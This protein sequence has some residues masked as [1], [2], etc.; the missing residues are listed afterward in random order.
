MAT[1]TPIRFSGLVSGIDFDQV[2]NAILDLRRQP[3]LRLQEER[4]KLRLRSELWQEIQKALSSLQSALSPLL[5]K[6]KGLPFKVTVSDPTV[7]QASANN[8]ALSG[9]YK[10]TVLQLATAVR[11]ATR[12]ADGATSLSADPNNKVNPNASLASESNKF[13]VV[14]STSGS[15]R[16]NGVEIPYRETDTLATILQRINNSAAG[17][18]AFYDPIADRVVLV[19]KQTGANGTIQ[20]EDVSGNFLAALGL[21]DDAQVTPGQD[22]L[23]MVEANGYFFNDGNPIARPSNT[24]TDVLPGIT[25][26]LLSAASDRPVTLIVEQDKSALKSAIKTFVEKFNAAVSLLHQRLTE[27]PVDNP[28]TDAE[29]KVGLLR[30]DSTVVN[31]KATLV[32]EATSVVE[33]IGSDLQ[34]LAQLGIRLNNDGTLSLDENRLQQVLDTMPERVLQVF[35]NDTDGD[36]RVDETDGGIAVRLKILLDGWLS[37]LPVAFGGISLPRGVVARQP[38]LINQQVQQLDR[39]INELNQ[40]IEREGER[41]RQQFLA[42]ERQL[43]MLQQRWSTNGLPINSNLLQRVG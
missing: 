5:D 17:V 22:A 32:R 1:N 2:V 37:S 40:R 4:T 12:F 29:R 28:R 19:S 33:G 31:L 38:A 13:R 25:L 8:N 9:T 27:K 30:G 34:M 16:L 20:R 18:L 42:M 7:V 14:P 24:V 23:F 15:F 11:I 26:Q 35:F 3:L 36:N 6:T 43:L 21:L 41:L 10:V 39:R